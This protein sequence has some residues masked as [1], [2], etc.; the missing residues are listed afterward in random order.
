MVGDRAF[1]EVCFLSA[2]M[3]VNQCFKGFW[4]DLTMFLMLFGALRGVEDD[5]V[6]WDAKIPFS[7]K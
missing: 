7:K 4:V 3:L 6:G 1:G 2:R 5:F